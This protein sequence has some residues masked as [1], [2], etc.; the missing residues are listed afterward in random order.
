MA[1]LANFGLGGAVVTVA[2]AG[3]TVGTVGTVG[4]VEQSITLL[5]LVRPDGREL[6]C[7]GVVVHQAADLV[8]S[9][10]EIS[11]AD[12]NGVALGYQT[13]VMC[14]R[15]ARPSSVDG[16]RVLATVL[17]TD[18]VGSTGQAENLGDS[19]WSELLEEH[20]VVVRKQL[21]VFKGQDHW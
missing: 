9:T 13:G 21:A 19:R 20:H 1:T 15:S 11:D 8:V 4:T 18:I 7:R 3:H 2:R 14:R 16:Q 10:L 5:R 6:V 17:F 12:G